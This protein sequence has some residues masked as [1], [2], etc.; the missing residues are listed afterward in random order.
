[1]NLLQI[2]KR[3]YLEN[4]E[5]NHLTCY[6]ESSKI[7]C[8]PHALL[9]SPLAYVDHLEVSAQIRYCEVSLVNLTENGLFP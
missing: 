7:L 8:F 6:F 5:W 9:F 4:Q 1:V 2:R 3:L